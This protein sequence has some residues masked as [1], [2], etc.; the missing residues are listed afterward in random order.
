MLCKLPFTLLLS[1]LILIIKLS[2]VFEKD[3]NIHKVS[4][5]NLCEYSENQRRIRKCIEDE[6]F[7]K[8]KIDKAKYRYFKLDNGLKVYLVSNE[9]IVN[10]EVAI[11][12]GVG[13][14]HDPIDIQGLSNLVQHTLLLASKQ[15]PDVDEF[16][17]FINTL[18]GKIYL[19]LHSKLTIYSF[20]IGSE[21]LNESLFRFSS[22][23]INPILSKDNVN[24]ALVTIF[25]I[26]E[27]MRTNEK[28]AMKTIEREVCEASTS[29]NRDI[30][31]NKN[32]FLNNPNLSSGELYD[33]VIDYFNNY[34]SPN[35]MTL[36]V[37]GRE[38]LEKL[39]KYVIKSFGNIK[40]NGVRLFRMEDSYKFTVNPFISIS[41]KI[42]SI[43][44]PTKKD[45]NTFTIR[46]PVEFQV[47][48]WKRIPALY[49]KYLLD[50]SYRGILR[51]Y[52]TKIG[53]SSKVKVSTTSFDGF[54]TLDI[55]VDL[56][57]K[58]LNRSWEVIGAIILALK[59]IV[60]SPVTE[61]LLNEIKDV[62]DL[63]FNYRESD[64][65]KDIAY[66]IAYKSQKYNIK[67]EEVIFADEV[68]QVLDVGFT[69]SFLNSIDINGIV[70]FYSTPKLL[71]KR[72]KKDSGENLKVLNTKKY[73]N[74]RNSMFKVEDNSNL[75]SLFQ[76][77]YKSVKEYVI[78]IYSFIF[79]E[80][81]LEDRE[82]K[83]EYSG[84]EYSDEIGVIN[85]T[86]NFIACN[87]ILRS[88]Y[89]NSEYCVN[90][91]PIL[92]MSE[93]H[94]MTFNDI[95]E[96]YFLD[97]DTPNKY[98][99][100]DLSVL[101]IDE[102]TKIIPQ[103]L[104][105]SIKR[106]IKKSLFKD[107]KYMN[108]YTYYPEIFNF[109]Y[110]NSEI[111]SIPE[112]SLSIRIQTP[113]ITSEL[114]K[115][116]PRVLKIVPRLI[117]SI[118][119]LCSTLLVALEDEI[120]GFRLTRNEFK[121]LTYNSYFYNSLPNGFTV[122]LSGYRDVIPTFLR[123]FADYLRNP[124]ERITYS[125]F[126]RGY[127]NVHKLLY[128]AVF[129]SS[130][131]MKSL[132]I[133]RTITEN[134]PLSPT[135]RFREIENVG[136]ADIMDLSKFLAKHGQLEGI[137]MNNIDP[138]FAG[139]ILNEFI[140]LLGREKNNMIRLHVS[141]NQKVSIE[142]KAGVMKRLKLKSKSYTVQNMLTPISKSDKIYFNSY[143]I[144]DITSLPDKLW[145]SYK[146]EYSNNDNDKSVVSLLLGVGTK[147]PFTIA[148]ATLSNIFLSDLMT[149]FLKKLSIENETARSFSPAYYSSLI[150]IIIQIDSYSKDVTYLTEFLLGFLNEVFKNPY[151]IDKNDFYI[152]KRDCIN[153]FKSLN[154]NIELFNNLFF[155][156]VEGSNHPFVWVEKVI[157]I[158]ETLTFARFLKLFKLLHKTPQIIVSIQSKL[159]RKYK[160][161][162]YLPSG[163]TLLNN[164]DSLLNQD[165]IYIYKLPINISPNIFSE[166]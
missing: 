48:Y 148:L 56:Y 118:E 29:F 57:N 88:K 72:V 49:I 114:S 44:R 58:E 17:N 37:V 43:K 38:P 69:E 8:S 91:I 13:F 164:T 25:N 61:R 125:D 10:S 6:K 59:F 2:C 140:S 156:F 135:E 126:K 139:D 45:I 101:E 1:C 160:F 149:M 155:T 121:I 74:F 42:I 70:I 41:G 102:R 64:F 19:D 52:F 18:N 108:E 65:Y 162:R 66:N 97:I 147:T 159:S 55:S 94:N 54:S 14:L 76:K 107:S 96:V 62:T 163:Y 161:D 143:E 153:K 92:F 113:V 5:L 9:N 60:E 11:S 63:L 28:W 31:G 36:S 75:I 87:S 53:V 115:I 7:V 166:D 73:I 81:K 23:F 145:R 4:L 128:K 120:H 27:R 79:K 99:P 154:N 129:H 119:I 46:I 165:N 151:L 110:K 150:F 67:P 71:L 146:F 50:S 83:G 116:V 80:L 136:Y 84:S 152:I 89:L 131:L 90:E 117:V 133:I 130:S 124:N 32:I 86:N 39:E 142:N 134:Q 138:I 137:F 122:I 82:M 85:Y 141:E 158:L 68:I 109:Y 34:Y 3:Y 103:P 30:L 105:F 106:Y 21:Y 35:I 157:Q 98:I 144:L 16:N 24:K 20:S 26:I 100:L 93:I 132:E 15:Y 22:Y 77:I 78:F 47:V 112:A 127:G 40:N 51:R 95:K 12:V 123:V 111:P 33:R 104:L